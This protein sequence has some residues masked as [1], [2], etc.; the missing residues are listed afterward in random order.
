MKITYLHTISICLKFYKL[1]AIFTGKIYLQTEQHLTNT[2]KSVEFRRTEESEYWSSSL[3]TYKIQQKIEINWTSFWAPWH[4]PY[5]RF[6][7]PSI[8]P[9][10]LQV[11]ILPFNRNARL[12]HLLLLPLNYSNRIWNMQ[13]YLALNGPTVTIN[14]NPKLR[15]LSWEVASFNWNLVSWHQLCSSTFNWK[16]FILAGLGRSRTIHGMLEPL[17]MHTLH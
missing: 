14:S 8:K 5:H 6:D 12:L 4:R 15:K 16:W 1:W 7:I 10:L 9:K 13:H 17:P 3:D 11:R 2:E